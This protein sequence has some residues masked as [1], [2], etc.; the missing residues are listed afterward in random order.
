MDC[1][2]QFY[3]DLYRLVIIQRCNLQLCHLVFSSSVWFEHE[4]AIDDHTDR[5]AW[6][7]C[8]CRLYIQIAPYDLL[9]SL[10]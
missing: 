1:R 5:K 3:C 7:D 8:Q 4:I 6:P 2:G 9:A 10:I